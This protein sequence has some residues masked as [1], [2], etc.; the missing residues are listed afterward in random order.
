MTKTALLPAHQ[1]IGG[2]Y[3]HDAQRCRVAGEQTEA[4]SELI[5]S[6]VRIL[7][8]PLTEEEARILTNPDAVE[9][10]QHHV[11]GILRRVVSWFPN[12]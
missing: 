12:R 4:A 10:L 3:E 9:Q 1:G 2:G 11:G 8:R 5:Q 6:F 7:G